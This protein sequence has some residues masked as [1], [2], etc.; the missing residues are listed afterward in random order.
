MELTQLLAIQRKML[1]S[2]AIVQSGAFHSM[3]WLSSWPGIATVVQ[4]S[5]MVSLAD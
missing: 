1:M 3:L 5:C 4:Q 2:F